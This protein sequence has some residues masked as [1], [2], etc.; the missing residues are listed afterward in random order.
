MFDRYINTGIKLKQRELMTLHIIPH[1]LDNTEHLYPL[2]NHE[3]ARVFRVHLELVLE[4]YF[5]ARLLLHRVGVAI[6][7]DDYTY[8]RRI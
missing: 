2:R 7:K 4:V 6:I 3:K 1:L 5:L 8:I